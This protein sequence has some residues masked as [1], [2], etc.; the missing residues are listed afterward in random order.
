MYKKMSRTLVCENDQFIA[1]PEAPNSRANRVLFNANE[2]VQGEGQS[3]RI[4][5]PHNRLTYIDTTQSWL[6]FEAITTFKGTG[7]NLA[8]IRMTPLGAESFIQNIRVF[9]NNRLINE[10]NDY[11]KICA[12]L[13]ASNVGVGNNFGN[14]LSAGSGQDAS[15]NNEGQKLDPQPALADT[16]VY[17]ISRRYSFPLLG[18]M[19]CG[20]PKMLPV[21]ELTS[22]IEIQITWGNSWDAFYQNTT[23]SSTVKIDSINSVFSSVGYSA[24]VITV[25]ESVNTEIQK[26]SRDE[27]GIMS[28]SGQLWSLDARNIL[29]IAQMKS[30]TN[31]NNILSGFRYKSLKNISCS[32]FNSDNTNPPFAVGVEDTRSVPPTNQYGFWGAHNQVRYNIAGRHYPQ[33]YLAADSELAAKTNETFGNHF[34]GTTNN[35]FC[36]KGFQYN[37][38]ISGVCMSDHT[39]NVNVNMSAPQSLCIV[40]LED[41]EIVGNAG[42]DT[43]AVQVV[44]QHEVDSTGT[45]NTLFPFDSV[46]DLLMCYCANYDVLYSINKDGIMSVSY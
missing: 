6:T 31:V 25:G 27:D 15:F 7:L 37:Q 44:A 20:N 28:W 45:G 32:G 29:T 12:M 23:A 5:L 9:V 26:R 39:E 33:T 3:H 18:L 22:D 17:P 40:P 13:Q 1:Y 43:T 2:A 38:R 4:R 21:G 46:K 34:N 11:S 35:T 42:I 30:G 14:S 8:D 24:H 41:S 36:S 16:T 10:F 19:G